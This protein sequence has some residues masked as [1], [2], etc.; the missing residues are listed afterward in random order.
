MISVIIPA[1]NEAD[2]IGS[3]LEELQLLGPDEVIVVND[4]SVDGT[5][6]IAEGY[7]V[8]LINLQPARGKGGA[9][10][11]GLTE[12]SGG[13]ILLIDA[14]LGPGLQELLVIVEAVKKGEAEMALAILPIAGGG[15][16]LVR[17]L[18]RLVVWLKTGRIIQAPLSGQ[19]AFNREILPLLLPLS[20]GFGLETGLNIDLLQQ[21][22]TLKE[23]PCNLSHRQ[24]GLTVS[25][26]LHRGGQF[27]DIIRVLWQK[28]R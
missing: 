8:K 18:A 21:G 11:A 3:T 25:G 15:F 26:F 1:H 10:A 28:R 24:T 2:R 7:P 12:A 27:L 17:S 14:D 16:G 9:V 13:I 22:F 19:R 6:E 5:A 23:I 4:G 20:P